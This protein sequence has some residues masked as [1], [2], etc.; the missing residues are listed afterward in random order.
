MGVCRDHVLS[1]ERGALSH[2]SLSVPEGGV[3]PR[4]TR[5][6]SSSWA[7][8]DAEA[9]AS[10]VWLDCFRQAGLR[11][12]FTVVLVGPELSAQDPTEA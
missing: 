2:G 3:A 7:L 10:H 6:A 4:A 11:G 8:S 9:A 1:A 5:F 12:S